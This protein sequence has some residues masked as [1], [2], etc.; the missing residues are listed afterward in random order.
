MLVSHDVAF[1]RAVAQGIVA[2]APDGG[3]VRRYA[4]GYDYYREKSAQEAGETAPAADKPPDEAKAAR[5]EALRDRKALKAE[6]RRAE[7][8]LAGLEKEIANLEKEQAEL[9]RR[10][11]APETPADRRAADGRRLKEVEDT[12]SIRLTAWEDAGK[13]RDSMEASG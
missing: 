10:L 2:V 6:L 3:G 9:H 1:V 7:K 8:E 12:L 4:G 5:I 11:A 13:R